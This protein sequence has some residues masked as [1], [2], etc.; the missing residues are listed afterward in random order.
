[1]CTRGLSFS[2]LISLIIANLKWQSN[3]WS[4]HRKSVIYIRFKAALK[5]HKIDQT[6]TR[7]LELKASLKCHGESFPV[8]ERV[9]IKG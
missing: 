8:L 7:S 4:T 1:V 5:R 3:K 9:R 2:T 6:V